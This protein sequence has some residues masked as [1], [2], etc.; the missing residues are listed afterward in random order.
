MSALEADFDAVADFE[1]LVAQSQ[2][3][4]LFPGE[5]AETHRAVTDSLAH[6]SALA[7]TSLSQLRYQILKRH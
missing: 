5:G 7:L 2:Y 1:R 4:R 6:L 3:Y